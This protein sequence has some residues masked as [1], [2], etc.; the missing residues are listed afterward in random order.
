MTVERFETFQFLFYSCL[1]MI[2]KQVYFYSTIQQQ[3]RFFLVIKERF[4]R[5]TE[6]LKVVK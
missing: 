2:Q 3:G 6:T 1:W 4:R 5:M